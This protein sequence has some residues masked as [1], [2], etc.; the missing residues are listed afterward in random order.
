MDISSDIIKSNVI[1]GGCYCGNFAITAIKRVNI[2]IG[3]VPAPLPI[4]G[5]AVICNG[6]SVVG[7]RTSK[8]IVSK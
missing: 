6:K 8:G 1:L 7:E 3:R 4:I 5:R 2:I